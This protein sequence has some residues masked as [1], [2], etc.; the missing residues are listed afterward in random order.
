[1]GQFMFSSL[2]VNGSM[3]TDFSLFLTLYL[4]DVILDDTRVKKGSVN[5]VVR[6]MERK[7]ND[8]E[9]ESTQNTID[10]K[11]KQTLT[12]SDGNLLV[13]YTIYRIKCYFKII[14]FQFN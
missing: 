11:Y 8:L 2:T 5:K 9:V 14:I 7:K 1:M 13:F 12:G 10:I 3:Q 4:L 6:Y